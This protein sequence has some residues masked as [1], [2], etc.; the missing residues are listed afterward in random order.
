M[1]R[2]NDRTGIKT[3]QKQSRTH[4]AHDPSAE[5]RLELLRSSTFTGKDF[6]TIYLTHRAYEPRVRPIFLSLTPV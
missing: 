6:K 5:A 2:V 1:S 4:P 3:N